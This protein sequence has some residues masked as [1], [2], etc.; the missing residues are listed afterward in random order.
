MTCQN[1]GLISDPGAAAEHNH[2]HLG[3]RGSCCLALPVVEHLQEGISSI[4][5][6]IRGTSKAFA[7]LQRMPFEV[8]K[9][10]SSKKAS[11]SLSL[12]LCEAV[13]G[14]VPGGVGSLCSS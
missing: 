13:Q 7:E 5:F 1:W 14:D 11:L 4:P 6:R 12:S 8:A 10:A 3:H 2:E 9:S